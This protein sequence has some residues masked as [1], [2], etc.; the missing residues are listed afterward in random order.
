MD[1]VRSGLEAA[2]VTRMRVD[3]DVLAVCGRGDGH[4]KTVHR[5]DAL[6]GELVDVVSADGDKVRIVV[7]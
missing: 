7:E 2:R 6:V 1:V 5:G 4:A 3:A